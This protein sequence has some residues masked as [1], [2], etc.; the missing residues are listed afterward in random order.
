MSRRVLCPVL[1]GAF[2]VLAPFFCPDAFADSTRVWTTEELRSFATLIVQ[3]RVQSVTPRWDP[4][5]GALYTYAAIDVAETLKGAAPADGRIV[6]KMLGGRL[7]DI[8]L[9]VGGQAELAAGEDVLLFLETRPR[10]G[11]LYPVGFWQGVWRMQDAA[12]AERRIPGTQL[13]QQLGLD[14]VRGRFDAP[15]PITSYVAIPSELASSFADYSYLPPSDGG[16]GRWHEADSNT[17]VVMDYEPFPIH[18]VAQ[19]DAAI[20]LWNGSGMNLQLQRGGTRG[21]RCAA[22]FE[23]DGRISV[24]FNDPCGEVAASGSVLGIG[25]AYMTPILRTIGGATYTKII[26]GAVVLPVNSS[27]NLEQRGCFQD[28]LTHNI[29]HAIGLAHSADSFA[30]M[31]PNLQ[32]SCGSSSSALG[33]DDIA[34]VRNLYPTGLS[35]T[36]PGRPSNLTATVNGSSVSLGWTASVLGGAVT[37]YVIEAGSAPGLTDLAN[38][39]TNS[40]ATSVSFVDVPSGLY[41]VRVRARNEVGTG[42]PSPDVL[43]AVN[44]TL[45][46]APRNFS[47]TVSGDT[48]TLNWAA[49]SSGSVVTNYVIEAGSSPGLTD[50][51]Q[52]STTGAQTSA[53]FTGVPSGVYYVRVRARNALGAGNASNEITVPVN[54]F[55][56]GAPTNLNVTQTGAS[57]TFTWQPPSGGGVTSYVIQVGSAPGAADLQVSDVGAITRL[58]ASG[59]PGTYYV[60]ILARSACGYSASGSNEVVVTIP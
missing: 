31:S 36:P 52:T 46:G 21:A 44:F 8:E 55:Q 9:R 39:A 38:V 57:V 28:A 3:G 43:V 35:I 33:N 15:G 10:D 11:T 34:A 7:P 50:R 22:T 54:C 29:G 6:V 26:Q 48:V 12:R 25:G 13:T 5:T 23:G 14:D 19:L 51:A 40:M 18:N 56:P 47:A 16:P 30:I 58:D 17:P 60:R 41:Y 49:P 59:P 1:T 53:T 27:P 20:T 37:T 45:P 4:A 24:T 32:A 42:T 2:L